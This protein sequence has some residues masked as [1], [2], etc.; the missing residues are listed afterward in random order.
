[1]SDTSTDK[2][3]DPVFIKVTLDQPVKRGD[4]ELTDIQLRRPNSGE[5]RGLSLIETGQLQVDTLIKL[6]PRI[7]LPRL[8][9]QEV[10]A[11]LPSDLLA[12]GAEVGNFLLP[13]RLRPDSPTE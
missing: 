10:E 9:P 2:T 8:T 6:L 11:L 7:T 5:L 3:N 1:M 4:T 12:L 13:K